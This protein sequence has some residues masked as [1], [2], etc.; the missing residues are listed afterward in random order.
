MAYTLFAYT[1]S[2]LSLFFSIQNSNLIFN[3]STSSHKN[4]LPRFFYSYEYAHDL[5][6]AN[7]MEMEVYV[8]VF[9]ENLLFSDK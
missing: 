5:H 4:S 9:A 3:N 2:I 8:A 7:E 1:I 6:L